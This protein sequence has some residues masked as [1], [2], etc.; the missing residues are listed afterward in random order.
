MNKVS[1]Y[2][3]STILFMEALDATMLYVALPKITMGFGG[4]LLQG[5]WII[6]GFLLAV[7]LSMFVSS[8]IASFSG[9]K[10]TF[11]LAQLAYIFSSLSCSFS[12]NLDQLI[13]F[14]ILQGT[15]A[16][17]VI[18]IGIDY[19]LR[20]KK[21]EDPQ[22]VGSK[23]YL[24]E[25]FLALIVGPIYAGYVVEFIG[26]RALFLIKLPVSVACFLA[27]WFLLKK[28]KI[29][30]RKSF[31][32]RGYLLFSLAL[33]FMIFSITKIGHLSTNYLSI[34]TT[35][36]VAVFSIAGFI[37]YELI[38]K[39]PIVNFHL[40][41][42]LKVSIGFA[43]QSIVVIVFMGA[44]FILSIFL[45]GALK[46]TIIETAWIVSSLGIGIWVAVFLMKAIE[47][48]LPEM[49]VITFSL[50]ILSISMYLL[51]S[52]TIDTPKL[53][54]A[55][56]IFIE[57]IAAGMFRT[58]N[59]NLIFHLPSVKNYLEDVSRVFTFINQIMI[60]LGVAITVMIVELN[61]DLHNITTLSWATPE[62]AKNAYNL[63]FYILAVLPIVGIF[64][65][66]ITKFKL[67]S[68]KAKKE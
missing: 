47:K 59:T 56:I 9:A 54:I 6:I 14:R 53:W 38:H 39:N 31:H 23:L 52:V 18:P 41:K 27:S 19:W 8:W 55:S 21:Q 26:W 42:D 2:L 44:I 37:R 61:L 66:G 17:I 35:F 58:V 49:F 7:A 30:E 67:K 57:G 60:T 33:F 24:Y 28:I 5:D 46:F 34:I 1:R 3:I 51:T 43:L 40:F 11:L 50:L 64:L 16:G 68:T 15:F 62:S 4:A 45:I 25:M 13:V 65:V 48:I 10:K 32:W 29:E 20:L 63:V 12:N 36:L 22:F